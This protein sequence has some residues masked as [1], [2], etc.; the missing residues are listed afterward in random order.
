VHAPALPRSR[1]DH[2]AQKMEE[3][4]I[5][6]LLDPAMLTR[7]QGL[8]A[9]LDAGAKLSDGLGHGLDFRRNGLGSSLGT[10]EH[11]ARFG[12]T[13]TDLGSLGQQSTPGFDVLFRK[14]QERQ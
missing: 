3:L 14:I 11:L 2:V 1:P 7:I 10:I 5:Q 8:S 12:Q 9:S 4:D 6:K 13:G